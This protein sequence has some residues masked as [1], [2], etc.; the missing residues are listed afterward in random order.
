MPSSTFNYSADHGSKL[1]WAFGKKL[2]LPGDATKAQVEAEVIAF[3]KTVFRDQKRIA[4]SASN[5]P[6]EIDIT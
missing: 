3:M 2:G 1:Q 5:P 6:E 4:D